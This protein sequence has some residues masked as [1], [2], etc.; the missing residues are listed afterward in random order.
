MWLCRGAARCSR[1]GG[2]GA[3]GVVRGPVG[4]QGGLVRPPPGLRSRHPGIRWGGLEELI[5]LPC[6]VFSRVLA[7]I[8]C[9]R[10]GGSTPAVGANCASMQQVDAL[11]RLNNCRQPQCPS[12]SEPP[13][14]S[15]V[16]Q[17]LAGFW[18]F[19]V[20]PQ[21]ECTKRVAYGRFRHGRRP[22]QRSLPVPGC[23][24][25][26]ICWSRRGDGSIAWVLVAASPAPLS[27]WRGLSLGPAH[28]PL[29]RIARPSVGAHACRVA[30]RVTARGAAACE[31]RALRL[32]WRP[33]WGL[34]H[35][36]LHGD[37]LVGCV[38]P[39]QRRSPAP[40]SW[41]LPTTLS[42]AA[43]A[44]R[45]VVLAGLGRARALSVRQLYQAGNGCMRLVGRLAWTSSRGAAD[46]RAV[47][48]SARGPS[49]SAPRGVLWMLR[50]TRGRYFL[51]ACRGPRTRARLLAAAHGQD[52]GALP[53]GVFRAG[54]LCPAVVDVAGAAG[55]LKTTVY[56]RRLDTRRDPA[57]CASGCP[58][59]PV[60]AEQPATRTGMGRR[61]RAWHG[62][63]T[64]HGRCGHIWGT[65]VAAPAGA[66]SLS[67]GRFLH[68][69]RGLWAGLFLSPCRDSGDAVH[70]PNSIYSKFSSE[71]N[72]LVLLK[73]S[74]VENPI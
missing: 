3:A 35:W 31:R 44:G 20:F 24:S 22:P 40:P 11:V 70:A 72:L 29:R 41:W 47:L 32:I 27:V 18:F 17:R 68:R 21:A 54:R 10:Q 39:L 1:D 6:L 38:R 30:V 46:G 34:G 19:G 15:S 74:S 71:N 36:I 61:F 57:Q 49:V 53:G 9:G 5:L 14:F 63:A 48:E 26:F 69:A 65:A 37:C 58:D 64:V 4:I 50:G 12:R 28:T 43:P 8:V 23:S 16:S 56:S 7:P 62:A 13:F 42:I 60:R 25:F 73:C 45:I 51:G 2:G 52:A 67:H 55:L 59:R 33:S 66:G